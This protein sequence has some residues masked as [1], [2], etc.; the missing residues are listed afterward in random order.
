MAVYM[1]KFNKLFLSLV[2]KKLIKF[3]VDLHAL[4]TGQTYCDANKGGGI[5]I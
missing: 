1:V 2:M 4:A 3:K 5:T